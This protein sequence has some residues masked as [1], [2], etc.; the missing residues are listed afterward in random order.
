MHAY[1]PNT[2]VI[3]YTQVALNGIACW[4]TFLPLTEENFHL[5]HQDDTTLFYP[6]DITVSDLVYAQLHRTRISY[7]QIKST[8]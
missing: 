6:S 2:G 7:I 4:D 5:I 3:L 1:D 8:D